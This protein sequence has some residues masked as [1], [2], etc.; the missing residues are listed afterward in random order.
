VKFH[1]RKYSLP[2]CAPSVIMRIT[3]AQQD[4][5]SG[6]YFSG[7]RGV[8]LRLQLRTE[9]GERLQRAAV[10]TAIKPDNS[11]QLATAKLPKCGTY[12]RL[13]LARP[14]AQIM[15]LSEACSRL[16][17]ELPRTRP[18]RPFDDGD[19]PCLCH[20]LFTRCPRMQP[21]GALLHHLVPILMFE[22]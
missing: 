1:W 5:V 11:I 6:R 22:S 8:T 17:S 9:P 4:R 20:A 16:L 13:W 21:L 12:T 7:R 10:A 19:Y 2:W 18:C 3:V 14:W 15:S